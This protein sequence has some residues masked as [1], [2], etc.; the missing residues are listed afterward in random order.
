MIPYSSAKFVYK[1]PKLSKPDGG[2]FSR[3]RWGY[4][5]ACHGIPQNVIGHSVTT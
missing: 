5:P 2:F 3:V 4:K 1:S